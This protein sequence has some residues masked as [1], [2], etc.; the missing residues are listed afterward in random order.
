M[1]TMTS[2]ERFSRAFTIVDRES[3][4]KAKSRMRPSRRLYTCENRCFTVELSL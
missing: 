3:W 1:D 4:A 2:R